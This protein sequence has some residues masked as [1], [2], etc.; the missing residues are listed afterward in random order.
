MKKAIFFTLVLLIL[1]CAASALSVAPRT[2][3]IQPNVINKTTALVSSPATAVSTASTTAPKPAT[4]TAAKSTGTLTTSTKPTITNPSADV[5]GKA[6]VNTS[7]SNTG[8]PRQTWTA[9]DAKGLLSE[10]IIDEDLSPD[11]WFG[12]RYD[13]ESDCINHYDKNGKLVAYTEKITD[14][15][16][17]GKTHTTTHLFKYNSMGNVEEEITVDHETGE[18]SDAEALKNMIGGLEGTGA[19]YQSMYAFLQQALEEKKENHQEVMEANQQKLEAAINAT[20]EKKE[21]IEEAK[22]A[23]EKEFTPGIWSR[24]LSF[25]G[26]RDTPSAVNEKQER[27]Q[28]IGACRKTHEDQHGRAAY[29]E[30]ST[31]IAILFNGSIYNSEGRNI[32]ADE[33]M[34]SDVKEKAQ[35]ANCGELVKL[36]NEKSQEWHNSRAQP[37]AE[38]L[39]G[40]FG[41]WAGKG[42]EFWQG[43]TTEPQEKL[44]GLID[45]NISEVNSAVDNGFFRKLWD[46]MV[47]NDITEMKTLAIYSGMDTRQKEVQTLS[48]IMEKV[49]DT[50]SEIVQ[51]IK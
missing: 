5:S 37:L 6:G 36:I 18:I 40:Q 46:R 12:C 44:N 48:N 4:T 25:I 50:E 51:N 41:G 39:P 20:E 10:S 33:S 49:N 2:L 15:S 43:D 11:S 13:E 42:V 17:P 19:I 31:I 34:I 7:G 27:M 1:T 24:F 30:N 26:I 32:Q 14:S 16:A 35:G 9:Q 47:G 23:A 22:D 38:K 45:K 29:M 8:Y 21:D 28:D 3:D